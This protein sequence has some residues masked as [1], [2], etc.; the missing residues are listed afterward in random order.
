MTRPRKNPGSS[1]I[2]TRDLPL[3]R[4]TRTG[5]RQ[6]RGGGRRRRRQ[7]AGVQTLTRAG[8]AALGVHS[9][10]V[11]AGQ[12]RTHLLVTHRFASVLHQHTTSVRDTEN[13][14]PVLQHGQGRFTVSQHEPPPPP[15]PLPP[16]PSRT[17][18]L[19]LPYSC[20]C[21]TWR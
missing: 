20:T 2:R 1:G 4:R 13:L 15:P 3:S 17:P 16:P 11:G 19:H 10:G 5:S 14:M 7:I 18:T 8:G 9:D 12:G 6:R 21:S